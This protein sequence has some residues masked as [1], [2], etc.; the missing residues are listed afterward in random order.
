M[1]PSTYASMRIG[2]LLLSQTEQHQRLHELHRAGWTEQQLCQ[3]SAYGLERCATRA[4]SA[5]AGTQAW[6]NVERVE[7][8]RDI[9]LAN[10]QSIE[11]LTDRGLACECSRIP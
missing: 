7:A 11:S 9:P 3:L 2:F 4:R 8:M 6:S 5:C 1:N 10:F